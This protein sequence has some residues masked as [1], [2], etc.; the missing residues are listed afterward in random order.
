MGNFKIDGVDMPKPSSWSTSPHI[1]TSDSERLA[2]SGRLVAP[3]LTTIMETEWHYKYL[4][5]ADYDKLY[6]AYILSCAR[7]RSIEHDLTTVDSN[8]GNVITY[9]VYTQSDFKAPLYRIR[10]GV[11]Y[12]RDVKFTF[13]GVGG[14]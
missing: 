9:R 13:V 12:Y 10:D 4:S 8:S 11:R 6:D 1:M 3:Y 14:E 5:Q 2:G 7:N